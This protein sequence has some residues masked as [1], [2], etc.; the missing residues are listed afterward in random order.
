MVVTMAVL[1]VASIVLVV[2]VIVVSGQ[3]CLTHIAV[4]VVVLG[5]KL[6]SAA[7]RA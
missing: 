6:S 4:I 1:F 5:R 3:A 2:I 7:M